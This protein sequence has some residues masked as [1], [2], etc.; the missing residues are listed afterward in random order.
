M[1]SVDKEGPEQVIGLSGAALSRRGFVKSGGTLLVGFGLLKANPMQ[2]GSPAVHGN[3]LDA[4]LPQSWIEIHPDNTIL[5]RVGKPDFGTGTVFTAY[6]QIVAEELSVPFEAITS[7]ISGDTDRTPDGSGA[8]DFLGRGMP[9]VRKAAAYVHQALLDLAAER[10]GVPKDQLTVNE[11]IVSGGGKRISYGDLVKNQNLTLT[12]PVEGELTSMFGLSV[13]GNPPLK[14]VNQY[15]V[16]GKSFPNSVTVSKVRAKE[17]WVTDVR[18]PGML[19]ARMV[20][21][22]TLGSKLVSVGPL[23]KSKFPNTRVIVKNNLVGVVA[24]TEWEAIKAAQQVAAGTK[25]SDWK[26]LPGSD[27]LIQFLKEDA[28]WKSV[29]PKTSEKSTGD[30][31]AALSNS[32]KK[33]TASYALP[34]FKHAPL[35]PAVAVG[36]VRADGTVFVYT[37]TQNPQA[38]RSG[39]AR[40]LST[41]VSKVVV[42]TFAGP[43]HYGRSNGGNAGAEDESVILSQA[44]GKPVRVQWMRHDDFQWSTQ[45]SAALADVQIG[46]DANGKMMAF[47]INHYMP[48]MQDDRLV[49][50]VLAGLPTIPAPDDKGSL[51]GIANDAHDPWIYEGTPAVLERAYGTAEI[52]K[53]SSPIAVGLRDHSMRTPGQY[54]QNYPRELAITEAALLARVDPLEFRIRHAR[55]QRAIGVLEAV[56][57][58]SEWQP[59]KEAP[60]LE[61]GVKRGQGVSAMFRAGSYWACVANIAV[62]MT[63]GV[64]KV[65]KITVAVDPGIVINPDQLKRQVEGGTVM[66]MSMALFEEVRFDQSGVTTSDWRNYPIATMADV[67]DIK[68]V[69]INSPEVGK[70][71]QGS[72]AANALASS[73][74]AG[75]FLDATG[76]PARRI[77][78]RPD[79]VQSLLKA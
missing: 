35:G 42:R 1:T 38:L 30:V 26:G 50:A 15:T 51:F 27:R 47:E 48:A 61:D 75:A 40:M 77:P 9:N 32:P 43:G 8:F 22:K 63:S 19:H 11:G 78:L 37:H 68:V 28:D 21:P 49:G 31:S 65:E 29:P 24:P 23:D 73:A 79:Y 6:R 44:V 52:G 10:L 55:D 12:I 58:S 7:V 62:N 13:A 4:A 67:P 25:W 76:K 5:M 54:Q 57:K 66:G 72:E 34:F 53:K 60:K 69:L 45:S 16:V 2:E 71:G 59:R 56:R 20:H 41:S 14:P 17:T 70:Y 46:L 33:L 36:D 3:S 39:I 18:L 74:I 64:V